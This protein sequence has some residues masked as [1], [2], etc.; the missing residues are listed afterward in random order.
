VVIE[1]ALA[2]LA[3]AFAVALSSEEVAHGKPAPD[4]YLETARRL[5]LAPDRRVAIEDSSTVLRSAAA[6]RMCVV[7]VPTRAY[8]PTD[9]ALTRAAAVV[10][11]VREVTRELI[12]SL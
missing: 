6:A 8:P 5:E 2:R 10:G 7:T 3:D 11:Q 4:L 1:A 12:A 9:D